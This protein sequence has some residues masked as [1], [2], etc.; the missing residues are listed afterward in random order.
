MLIGPNSECLS[1]QGGCMY[2]WSHTVC[3]CTDLQGC[4][5]AAGYEQRC[6]ESSEAGMRCHCTAV[7]SAGGSATVPFLTP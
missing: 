4:K 6:A 2:A 1:R 3:C 7:R 5:Q